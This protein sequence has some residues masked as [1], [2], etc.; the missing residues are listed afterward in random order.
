MVKCAEFAQ[1]NG[2]GCQK[3]V[4]SLSGCSSGGPAVAAVRSRKHTCVPDVHSSPCSR[5][6][7]CACGRARWTGVTVRSR[8]LRHGRSIAQEYARG[9]DQQSMNV[10]RNFLET[11]DGLSGGHR[12]VRPPV[13]HRREEV[14]GTPPMERASL[15]TAN[16]SCL[17]TASPTRGGFAG[18]PGPSVPASGSPP[19]EP[20][21]P[22]APKRLRDAIT[23]RRPAVPPH[24]APESKD[25]Q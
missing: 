1:N 2:L 12:T 3:L 15:L 9:S 6:R 19:R 16:G 10:F 21:S 22:P 24:T 4:R 11:F 14:D 20:V 13:V 17:D 18:R 8:R 5:L 7:A 25:E 23:A